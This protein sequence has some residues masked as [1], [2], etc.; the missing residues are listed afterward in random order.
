MWRLVLTVSTLKS[1]P[2]KILA[3]KLLR[4]RIARL[5]SSIRPVNISKLTWVPALYLWV[6]VSVCYCIGAYYYIFIYSYFNHPLQEKNCSTGD[7]STRGPIQMWRQF[8]FRKLDKYSQQTKVSSKWPNKNY[9]PPWD[10]WYCCSVVA[11]LKLNN[12]PWPVQRGS[13]PLRY[14]L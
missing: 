4:C 14:G 3:S 9:W 6:P 11:Y 12:H 2:E 7:H 13:L 10:S 8:M 5:W 1:E